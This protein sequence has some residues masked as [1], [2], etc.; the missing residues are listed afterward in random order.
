M[1]VKARWT[2]KKSDHPNFEFLGGVPARSLSEEEYDALPKEL[3]KAVDESPLFSVA[4]NDVPE[5]VAHH[6]PAVEKAPE[7]GG[8]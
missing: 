4:G 3:R 1:A 2:G 8:S 5:R 7:G 6:A